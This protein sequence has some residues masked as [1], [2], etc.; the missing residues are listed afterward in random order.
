MS[1]GNLVQE[2]SQFRGI[3]QV[4]VVCEADAVGAVDVEGLGLST[5]AWTD[6]Q[7]QYATGSWLAR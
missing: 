6:E 2:L 4:A 5:R 3:H 1:V 7:R